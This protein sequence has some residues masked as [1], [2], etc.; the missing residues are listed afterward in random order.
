MQKLFNS[1]GITIT[2]MNGRGLDYN[3]FAGGMDVLPCSSRRLKMR[4][5]SALPDRTDSLKRLRAHTWSPTSARLITDVTGEIERSKSFC[6]L[7]WHFDCLPAPFIRS[8]LYYERDPKLSR[9]IQQLMREP[10]TIGSDDLMTDIVEGG[11]VTQRENL[12]LWL[13]LS[14]NCSSSSESLTKLPV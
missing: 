3:S 8:R 9:N 6:Y 10:W 12:F 7:P 5:Q 4:C 11:T 2:T 1:S 14:R 13:M